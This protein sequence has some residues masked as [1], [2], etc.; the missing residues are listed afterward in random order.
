[1]ARVVGYR[2]VEVIIVIAKLVA[3]VLKEVLLHVRVDRIRHMGTRACWRDRD[4]LLE[5][6]DKDLV[7]LQQH[8]LER[9]LAHLKLH[10]GLDYLL[11]EDILVEGLSV[12]E[13][14]PA[15]GH[16]INKLILCL[17]D[18]LACVEVL[19]LGEVHADVDRLPVVLLLDVCDQ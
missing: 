2:Y 5:V 13:N 1:M 11:F 4:L 10:E 15:K 17:K 3:Q 16:V 14:L 8:C 19:M 12:E 9:D 7:L 6:S 18:Y